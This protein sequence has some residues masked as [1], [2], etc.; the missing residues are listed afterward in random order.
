MAQT[1]RLHSAGIKKEATKKRETGGEGKKGLG[2]GEEHQSQREEAETRAPEG[3]EKKARRKKSEQEDCIPTWSS[4]DLIPPTAR[5]SKARKSRETVFKSQRLNK[6]N[7][8]R[9]RGKMA[10]AN[11]GNDQVLLPLLSPVR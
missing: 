11:W 2:R 7:R 6:L 4:K 5:S 3:K 9:L 10:S 8:T 1:C